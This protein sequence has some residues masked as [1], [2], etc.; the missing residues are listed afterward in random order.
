VNEPWSRG[1]MLASDIQILNDGATDWPIK[2]GLNFGN[3]KM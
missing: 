2:N 1:A 3:P